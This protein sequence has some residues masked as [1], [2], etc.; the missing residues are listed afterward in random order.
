[1]ARA[2]SGVSAQGQILAVAVGAANSATPNPS[3]AAEW[4]PTPTRS[5]AGNGS[6]RGGSAPR[7]RYWSTMTTARPVGAA[8]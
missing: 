5:Q 3:A 2:V 1:M 8:A 7:T 6:V 4:T